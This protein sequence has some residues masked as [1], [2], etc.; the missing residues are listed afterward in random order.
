MSQTSR[1]YEVL[2]VME[3]WYV[4]LAIMRNMIWLMASDLWGCEV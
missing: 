3:K 1:L 2:E 4:S